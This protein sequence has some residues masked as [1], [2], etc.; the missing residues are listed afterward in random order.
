MTEKQKGQQKIVNAAKKLFVKKGFDGTSLRDIA[1]KAQ[2]PVSLIYHYF[3]NKVHLWQEV[4]V[5][6][7]IDSGWMGDH[8]LDKDRNFVE[9]LEYFVNMRLKLLY[10]NPDIVRLFDWQRLESGKNQLFGLGNAPKNGNWKTLLD[11]LQI[12]RKKGQVTDK[13][14]DEAVT[15]MI[16]GLILG[17]FVRTGQAYFKNEDECNI[18][19][20]MITTTLIQTLAV[21]QIE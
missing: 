12:Y 2:V 18:Y 9:F 15:S 16:F 10:S 1:T 11:Y 7:L 19:I 21:K 13:L 5:N 4:K 17:P 8:H 6:L 20:D 3:E 14:S